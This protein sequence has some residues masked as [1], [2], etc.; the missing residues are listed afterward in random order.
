VSSDLKAR[1]QNDLNAA[2][3]ERDKLR[4]LVIST[5]LS[6]VRN[7]E[8]EIGSDLDDDGVTQVLGRAIKQR[9]DAADQMRA[10]GRDE[11]ADNEDA[12]ADVLRAYLPEA[13]SED[14]VRA[15]VREIIASGADQMGP[16]MGQLMPRI[17]GRFDGKDAN[18]VVREEL[19]G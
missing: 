5:V 19:A 17:R 10:A 6:E 1:L 9:K 8:I 15:I 7:K 16:L 3:K 18:R 13:L 11:L 14:E 2:R 4:T 12:Q